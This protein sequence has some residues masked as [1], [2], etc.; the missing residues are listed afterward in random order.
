MF[1]LFVDKHIPIGFSS[2]FGGG[3]GLAA[4]GAVE[5]IIGIL[6]EQ[7]KTKQRCKQRGD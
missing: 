1:E 7:E 4:A 2:F 3:V 6:L 5:D